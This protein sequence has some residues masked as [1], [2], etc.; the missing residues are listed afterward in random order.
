MLLDD[1]M[2]KKLDSLRKLPFGDVVTKLAFFDGVLRILKK[3]CKAVSG[4][5]VFD[6]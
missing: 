3:L 4:N 5:R 1:A 2:L 6:V